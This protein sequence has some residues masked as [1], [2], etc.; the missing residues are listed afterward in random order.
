MFGNLKDCLMKGLSYYGSYYT[1]K[2]SYYGSKIR[3]KFNESCLKQDK[4]TYSHG[5]IANIYIVYEITIL[6]VIQH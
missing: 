6:A 1:P 2:L 5:T 4:A 3:V